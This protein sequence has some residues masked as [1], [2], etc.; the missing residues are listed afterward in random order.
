MQENDL[1]ESIPIHFLPPSLLRPALLGDVQ[2]PGILLPTDKYGAP[3][4]VIGDKGDPMAIFLG[5]DHKFQSFRRGKNEHWG[6]LAIEGIE[7]ELQMGSAVDLVGPLKRPGMIIRK[8]DQLTFAAIA[9]GPF[10]RTTEIPFQSGLPK[11]THG[12][13]VGFLEWRAVIAVGKD[14]YTVWSS[15]LSTDG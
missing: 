5:D 9:E 8:D 4:L 15:S 14:R 12:R 13:E 10:G 7:I 1:G 3:F 6:G 11:A 2:T